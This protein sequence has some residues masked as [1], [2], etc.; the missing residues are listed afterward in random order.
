MKKIKLGIVMDDIR[1]I[2]VM[3]DSTLR[4]MLEAQSRGW[5]LYYMQAQDLS[6]EN[7]NPAALMKKISVMLNKDKWFSIE[8]ETKQ[9]LNS[10]HVIL[11]RK[12]PPIDLSYFY[13][14]YILEQA[15]RHGVPVINRPSSLREVNEK[16]FTSWFSEF[17]PKTLV[18]SHQAE[19]KGF[20]R[21]VKKAVIKPLNAMGGHSIFLLDETDLNCNVI[22]ETMTNH[23]K[24][25]VM[26]QQ[27]IDEIKNGDKRILIIDGKVIPYAVTRIAGEDD[28]RGNVM[29]G[30]S[31]EIKKLSA[32]D[33][34]ICRTIAPLLKKKGLLLAGIDII[35]DY[36][37]E[38]NVTSPGCLTEIDDETDISATK[39]FIDAIEKHAGNN[40]KDK[41]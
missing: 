33:K 36:L 18:S 38:I 1:Y 40:Y 26:M 32:K 9:N 19:L 13:L 35:G 15:E 28:F 11:M 4:M 34:A 37:T 3:H 6:L 25:M 27:Y 21:Q 31:V 24:Q 12:D 39:I 20:L 10:L 22:L 2:R 30:A 8:N 14:T 29:S 16:L 17:C 23:G 41:L 7:G 5:E